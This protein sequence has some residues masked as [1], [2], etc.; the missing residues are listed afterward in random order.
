MIISSFITA[1]NCAFKVLEPETTGEESLSKHESLVVGVVSNVVVVAVVVVE[2]PVAILL[3]DDGVVLGIPCAS[4]TAF[5]SAGGEA[6]Q[7]A[8][9][10]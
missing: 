4:T 6:V 5:T 3:V 1:S 9:L 8:E 2:V 10:L 7:L